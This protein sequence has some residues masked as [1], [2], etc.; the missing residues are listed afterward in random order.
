MK[1]YNGSIVIKFDTTATGN[2]GSGKEVTVY[3]TGT[4]TK[5]DLFADNGTTPLLNPVTADDNGNYFFS[6]ADGIY[7]LVID[8]GLPS[9]NSETKVQ[10][11]DATGVANL[12][13]FATTT[14]ISS[15]IYTTIGE[16]VQVTD[17][18]NGYFIITSGGSPD[19]LGIIDAG[20]GN[21]AVV[22]TT[23]KEY[24]AS[25]LN[26]SSGNMKAPIEY[27]IDALNYDTSNLANGGIIELDG[28]NFVLDGQIS[29]FSTVPFSVDSLT[30]SG[31]GV[32]STL[33]NAS[34]FAGDAMNIRF[35]IYSTYSNFSVK[36]SQGNGIFIDD[37]PANDE[38]GFMNVFERLTLNGNTGNG[39]YAGRCFITTYRN[40][41]YLSN[42]ENGHFT[43]FRI[44][45]SQMHQNSYARNNT[46]SGFSAEYL[47]Y[48]SY[49]TC[50]SDENLQGWQLYGCR[51]VNLRTTGA[52]SNR[53][54]GYYIRSDSV[55]EI[56]WLSGTSTLAVNN[57][58]D[59]PA[60]DFANHT[61][62]LAENNITNFMALRQ[63]VSLF[64]A[65]QSPNTYDFKVQGRGAV[66]SIQDPLMENNGP[67][68]AVDGFIQI[69]YSAPKLVYQM[70]FTALQS[71]TLLTCENQ[72]GLTA[73]WSG[74]LLITVSNSVFGDPSSV[75][76][77]TYKLLVSQS[78]QGSEEVLIASLGLVNGT[79]P[80]HPSFTFTA[81][82]G[83]IFAKAVSTTA[84][85][86]WFAVEKVSGNLIF[87]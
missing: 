14:E 80:S 36:G 58:L 62:M 49:D 69:N 59:E 76:T 28:G 81:F 56:N 11:F 87:T 70:N 16:T 8:E 60:T 67:K 57:N 78:L 41:E 64:S 46:G 44:H 74:E 48:S 43:D 37:G 32:Q 84:G 50:G 75:G 22:D 77:A 1:K 40:N 15:G 18:G 68:A 63:P 53:R 47:I 5:A 33:L 27:A 3:I 35:P 26:A 79:S 31:K 83:G 25:W 52:E 66:L 61:E 34:G 2:A 4:I 54:A 71:R 85:N 30:F 42:S 13:N 10:I 20:N 19:G 39:L 38:P 23:A 51:G 24:Q 21:T 12:G 17:R 86:F 82:G 9:Q 29:V 45:T 7:D 6:V 72:N 73:D 55:H 65:G